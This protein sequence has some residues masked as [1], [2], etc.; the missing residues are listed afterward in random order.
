MADDWSQSNQNLFGIFFSW[1]AVTWILSLDNQ[2]ND[3]WENYVLVWLDHKFIASWE[4]ITLSL[5][6]LRWS[7]Q[8][9]ICL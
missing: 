9:Y 8:E 1:E 5:R 4:H 7:L 2:K 6:S 3:N